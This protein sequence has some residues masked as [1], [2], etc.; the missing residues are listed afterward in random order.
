[1]ERIY[2]VISFFVQDEVYQAVV[3]KALKIGLFDKCKVYMFSCVSKLSHSFQNHTLGKDISD[4]RGERIG[5]VDSRQL[6]PKPA[7]EGKKK[8]KPEVNF[9]LPPYSVR[10][11]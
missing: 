4:P 9:L 7:G 5:Y 6:P 3:E 10:S 11:N 1:M 8:S 2:A